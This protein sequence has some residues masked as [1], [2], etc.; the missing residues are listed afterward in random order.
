MHRKLPLSAQA[1]LPTLCAVHAQ[2]SV[3]AC[4]YSVTRSISS[5][6]ISIDSS[7]NG[8]LTATRCSD[9]EIVVNTKNRPHDRGLHIFLDNLRV[10]RA[11]PSC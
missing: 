4:F 8:I 1:P 6:V 7:L 5:S 9:V 2:L 11:R 3:F 10:R